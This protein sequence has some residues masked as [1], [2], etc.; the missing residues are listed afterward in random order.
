MS[1][2]VLLAALALAACS[3]RPEHLAPEDDLADVEVAL[4]DQDSTAFTFPA[5]LRGRP[6]LVSAVYTHCPD[7]CLMTMANVNRI[8]RE[9]GADSSRVTFA[10]VTFDP[11]RDTPAVLRAYA[12]A[13]KTGEDWHLLTGDSTAIAGMMERLGVRYEVSRRDTLA[14]GETIYHISHSDKLFLLDAEGRIVET[15]G[16]SAAVPEMVVEDARALL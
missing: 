7:V 2:L 8:K 10:T 15:Y 9:L 14:S 4:L 6:S 11:V 12:Q 16:G 1:R 5:D 3:S 13:W